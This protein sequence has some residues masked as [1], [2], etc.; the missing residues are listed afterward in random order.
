[1]AD[2][3]AR[4]DELIAALCTAQYEGNPVPGTDPQSWGRIIRVASK[5]WDSFTRR[6][7][8][9][10]ADTLPARVEDLARGLLVR[11]APRT[12][13]HRPIE[14][15]DCRDLAWRLA[16]VLGAPPAPDARVRGPR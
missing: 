13:G 10:A 8:V 6:H 15:T 14:L 7:P 11:C 9:P 1:M 5:R 4:T 2:T 16:R 12:G 3:T